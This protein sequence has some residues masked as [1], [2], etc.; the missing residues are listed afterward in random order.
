MTKKEVQNSSELKI[1]LP[2]EYSNLNCTPGEFSFNAKNGVLASSRYTNI[3][4]QDSTKELDL[5]GLR[6]TAGSD[7][8]FIQ[9]YEVGVSLDVVFHNSEEAT[10]ENGSGRRN[11]ELCV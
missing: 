10:A 1:E 11:F 5:T 9:Q 3:S 4:E 7:T 6:K 2:I 8:L